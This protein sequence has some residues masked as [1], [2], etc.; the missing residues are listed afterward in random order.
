MHA[1]K[2]AGM[3]LHISRSYKSLHVIHELAV[4]N[5]MEDHELARSP[6]S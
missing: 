1:G 2:Q 6:I 4:P 3:Q 5:D